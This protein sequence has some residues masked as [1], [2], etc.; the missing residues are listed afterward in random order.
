MQDKEFREILSRCE[1]LREMTIVSMFW[2]TGVRAKE[3]RGMKIEDMDVEKGLIHI[4]NSKTITG[5][6]II[7]IH[8]NFKKLLSQYLKKRRS[9]INDENSLFL[10]KK[11]SSFSESTIIHL[12]SYLQRDLV[13]NFSCH[14]FRR[15][16]V[17]RLYRKTKDLVLC[18]RLAG[19]ANI[20][21]TRK[22]IL[23]DIDEHMRKFNG[24]NF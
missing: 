13:I 6:R 12:V 5:Y 17:T 20:G 18:Q 19:H 1:G 23:D 21:T 4:T 10:T 7:P 11:G 15:A 2:Y 24:I 14:D 16:F 8:P 3:L 9:I 22:Y